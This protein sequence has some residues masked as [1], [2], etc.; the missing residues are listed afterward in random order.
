MDRTKIV[1]KAVLVLV[2]LNFLIISVFITKD[3]SLSVFFNRNI[4]LPIYSVETDDPKI[5]LSFDAAWG[6]D[7]CETILA[8]LAKYDVR[9][10]F[11][12]VGGW[13]SRYP[14]DVI[15]FVVSGHD[16]GNHSENHKYMG[17]LSKDECKQELMLAHQRIKDIAGI[18]MN[19]FRPPYG[20]YNNT[21]IEAAEESGYYTIQW[22]VD[23]HDWM[24]L[25]EDELVERVLNH[26]NLKNGS[27]ILMHNNADYT[28]EALERIIVGLQEKGY[29]LVP[30]SELIIKENYTI[31]FTGRQR[32]N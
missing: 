21:V 5:A 18:D 25:T 22:D 9:A 15:S 13:A 32:A 11:F 7:D 28:A 31:D 2:I 12:L 24:G 3:S 19:L 1:K 16:I 10:T 27:I 4:K 17:K 30:I 6:N 20:E 8:T 26:K 23:S 14:D 29:T